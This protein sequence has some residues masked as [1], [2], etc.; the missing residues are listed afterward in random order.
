[1]FL[2][3]STWL[4]ISEKAA[5]SRR[6]LRIS[7]A[8]AEWN[9]LAV[10]L[11]AMSEGYFVAE[12]LDEIE[13]VSFR[14]EAGALM[15]REDIQVALLATGAVDIAIDPRATYVLEASE[16]GKPLCI[17]AARRRT[18]AFV[19]I[20]QKGLRSLEDRRG[21]TVDMGNRGGAT[22]VMLREVL[23]DAGMQPDKDVMFV[24]SGG[25]MHARAE[26]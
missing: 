7:A 13:L 10:A 15:D 11:V 14:E 21:M 5:S 6:R 3:P 8:H 9:H 18:H 4:S 19:V 17:I 23:K 24:Y 16:Q 1:M 12:G 22:D 2:Q 20:G 26:T 25:P